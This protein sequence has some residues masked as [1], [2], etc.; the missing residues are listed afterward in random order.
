MFLIY[1]LNNYILGGIKIPK[2]TTVSVHAYGIMHNQNVFED[3]ETFK[4][5]R[6]LEANGKYI[7]SRPM[8]FIPFGMGRRVCLGEKLALNDMF[9][10]VV[11]LL[12]GTSGYEFALP[13]GAGTANLDPDIRNPIH[14]SACEYKVLLK[15]M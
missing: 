7:S 9:L 1:F 10:I 12:Q 4:P 13:D 2:N 6:F 3:P 5:E 8:G 15:S 11:N 14:Y